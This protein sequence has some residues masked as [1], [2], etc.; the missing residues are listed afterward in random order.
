MSKQSSKLGQTNKE[1]QMADSLYRQWKILELIPRYPHTIAIKTIIS[2]LDDQGIATPA[3]RT[4]QRDIDTLA[5]VF[6]HLQSKIEQGANCW[7]IGVRDGVLEIPKMETPTALAFFLA[8]KSLKSQLPPHALE[9]LQA[10]FS[11]ATNI[12]QKSSSQD[13]AWRDKIRVL[14]QTQQLIA[15]EIDPNVLNGI[16]K[17]LLENTRFDCKYFARQSD[18]FKS[19][20]VNPLAIIFRGTVSY[21]VC[22]INDYSD[23]RLLS[24]HRF[25]E[26]IPSTEPRTEPKGYKLDQ[27]IEQGHT[28]FLLGDYIDLEMRIDEEV[29]IHLRESK[30]TEEQQII[31]DQNGQSI[32]K[33]HIQNTGQLRWWLLGFADQIEIINPV[34]LREEF[35]EKT[36]AMAS[37]Y[38]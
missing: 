19:Y 30:L 22:T 33:A 4:I 36:R 25:V 3:Y 14:P 5:S 15:P 20:R 34:E 2:R 13:A 38:N 31:P 11:T 7:Y 18:Q 9:Y 1:R 35:K 32:F 28:D 37:K 12:L 27:Y 10:H 17:S 21:L 6:P 16:Y 8:E 26:A 23:I 24:L 29:A